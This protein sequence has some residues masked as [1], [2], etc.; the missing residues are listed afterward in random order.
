MFIKLKRVG[1]NRIWFDFI[2]STSCRFYKFC[3]SSKTTEASVSEFA[4]EIWIYLDSRDMFPV[5][6]AQVVQR[7][8]ISFLDFAFD[9]FSP[10][11]FAFVWEGRR[12][13]V[14]RKCF[15]SLELHHT[16]HRCIYIANTWS[17]C[18]TSTQYAKNSFLNYKISLWSWLCSA[19]LAAFISNQPSLK[20]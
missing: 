9:R 3:N 19:F 5:S 4:L 20:N 13:G 1:N 6:E 12:G 10:G 17:A 2:F 16:Q 18:L 15:S 7:S 14:E 8:A 11:T